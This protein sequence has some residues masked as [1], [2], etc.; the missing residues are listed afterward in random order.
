MAKLDYASLA[1]R[2]KSL[3]TRQDGPWACD[4]NGQPVRKPNGFTDIH[5][6]LAVTFNRAGAVLRALEEQVGIGQ[7]T[8]RHYVAID[9]LL[10]DE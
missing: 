3:W 10:G 2:A 6:P 1:V 9:R 5:S 7:A 4:A 8:N